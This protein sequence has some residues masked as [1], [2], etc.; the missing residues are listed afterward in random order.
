MKK[1]QAV[2]QLLE[3]A[4]EQQFSHLHSRLTEYLLKRLQLDSY[5]VNLSS[6]TI[7]L[8]V[9]ATNKLEVEEIL[10]RLPLQKKWLYTV[11]DFFV[12]EGENFNLPSSQLN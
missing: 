9:F 8:T 6:K 1:F 5:G 7:W 12:F 11:E 10:K 2:L 4:D 3:E